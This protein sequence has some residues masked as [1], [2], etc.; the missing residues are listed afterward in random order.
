MLTILVLLVCTGSLAV[1]DSIT[2]YQS[3]SDG[4]TLVSVQGSFELGFFSPGG[5][6]KNRYLGIWYK[7]IPIRTV[8]WVANRCTPINGS[9]G[10]LTINDTGNLVLSDQNKSVVWS[11][12]VSKQAKKPK[13]EL[14]DSGNLVVREEEDTNLENYLWQS[15]DNPSDTF[16]PEMKLGWDLRTGLNRRLSAWKNW[17]DPCSSDFTWGIEF[18]EQ[19]HTFPEVVM[20]RGT[21]ELTRSGPWNGQRFSGAPELRPNP[22]FTFGFANNDDEVY[23]S[24]SLNNKSVISII[25]LNSTT[26]TRYRLTWIESEQIWK[27]YYSL[28]RDYCELMATVS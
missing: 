2:P 10:I 17:D 6:S 12:R 19:L 27:T 3:M 15:F 5:S 26:S 22:V 14:L 25:V 8:V 4:T 20:R 21:V 11:T 23:Y 16:L 24:Y 1:L 18:D 7:N 9:S 13:V 28:P